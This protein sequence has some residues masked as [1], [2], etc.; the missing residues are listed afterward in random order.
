METTTPTAWPP[1]SADSPPSGSAI[2][3]HE[4]HSDSSP[5]RGGGG[6]EPEGQLGGVVV[7]G[8]W[9]EVGSTGVVLADW[10]LFLDQEDRPKYVGRPSRR[11]K[12]RK[13]SGGECL[14]AVLSM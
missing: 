10:W 2:Q 3:I 5:V 4:R 13:R 8:D 11:G 6:G 1:G 14:V 12:G 7:L 9:Q